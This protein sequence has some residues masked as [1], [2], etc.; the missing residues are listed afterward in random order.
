MALEGND[1][2]IEATEEEIDFI[3]AIYKID[4]YEIAIKRKTQF[5][6]N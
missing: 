3:K 4:H 2:D 6:F 5:I 1:E